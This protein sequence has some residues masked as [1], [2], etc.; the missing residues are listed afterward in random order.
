MKKFFILPL[1]ILISCGKTETV[2]TVQPNYVKSFKV[3]GETY[4]V[5][6]ATDSCEYYSMD[7]ATGAYTKETRYFHYPQCSYCKNK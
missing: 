2:T 5:V 7:I 3:G 1:M 6:K 4:E